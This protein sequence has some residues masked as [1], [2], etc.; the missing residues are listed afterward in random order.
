ME[1]MKLAKQ[2]YKQRTGIKRLRVQQT[3]IRGT[4]I[5]SKN[6][7]LVQG[8]KMILVKGQQPDFVER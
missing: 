5:I 3:K 8:K 7:Y 4:N 1:Q 2:N 6:L